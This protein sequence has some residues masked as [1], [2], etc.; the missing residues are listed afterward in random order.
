MTAPTATDSTSTP[1]TRAPAITLDKQAGAPTGT[2]AGS[3][4]TYT[5]IVTNSGNVTLSAPVTVNIGDATGTVLAVLEERFAIRGRIGSAELTDPVRAGGAVSRNA[6]DTPRRRRRDVTILAPVDMRPF[7]VVS[8]DHNPIHTDRTAA[9]LAGLDGPIVHGMWLSAAALCASGAFDSISVVIRGTILQM[10]PPDHLRG[11]VLAVNSIFISS[12][13]EL[14]AVESGLVASLTNPVF[15]VVAG[16]ALV[17]LIA[18]SGFRVFPDLRKPQRDCSADPRRVLQLG[19]VGASSTL[20][21]F[22]LC[23]EDDLA[24][25]EILKGPFGGLNDDELFAIANPRQGR[26]WP[27]VQEAKLPITAFL[28]NVLERRHQPP[29]EFLTH[30][31]ERGH[32]L[33]LPGWELILS[34]F[35]G[36]AREPVTALIDRASAFDA[37]QAPS[38]QTF[39]DAVERR[40]IHDAPAERAVVGVVRPQQQHRHAGHGQRLT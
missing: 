2:T 28:E 26:L 9:L 18:A 20:V 23:P 36:P 37:D 34:R 7:A 21:R 8:G 24:L 11:R 25:A 35:G 33:P 31:L 14:G 12:S 40:W 13:N 27:A 39:L 29:F 4:I 3:T 16:G 6:T 19:C 15:T 10:E 30:A 17:L 1:I 5:F 22:A 32:G 38:L